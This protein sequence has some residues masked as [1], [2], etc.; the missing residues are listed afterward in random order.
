MPF[1]IILIKSNLSSS[2]LACLIYLYKMTYSEKLATLLQTKEALCSN[3]IKKLH[4]R[5]KILSIISGGIS[6]S[7]ILILSVMASPIDLPPL[8]ITVLSIISAT[9][10]AVDCKFKLELKSKEMYQHL[11]KLNRIQ[12]KLQY[13]NSCN[14]NLTER[15]YEDLFRDCNAF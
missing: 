5:S 3:K 12:L 8:A 15:D 9:L 14:G 4:K 7:T 11:E 10:A 13:I 1:S 6:I 2:A